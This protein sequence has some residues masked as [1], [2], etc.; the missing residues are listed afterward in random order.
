MHGPY[1]IKYDFLNMYLK[2]SSNETTKVLFGT[3]RE[4]GAFRYNGHLR[5]TQRLM[6]QTE[7][8]NYTIFQI[9]NENKEKCGGKFVRVYRMEETSLL[10]MKLLEYTKYLFDKFGWKNRW[11]KWVIFYLNTRPLK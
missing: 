7:V 4:K 9:S 11:F 2:C 5:C 3:G 6:L 8:N 1:N 10:T